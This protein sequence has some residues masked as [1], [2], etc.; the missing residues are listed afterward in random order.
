MAGTNLTFDPATGLVAPETTEIREAVAADW[1]GA[2]RENGC[3]DLEASPSTPA[4]QLI[5]AET[6]EIE[7]KNAQLLF[8]SSMFDP[9]TSVGR[10]QE[11]L[12][13][14][15][16]ISRKL[17]EPT[18][19]TCQLTGLNGTVIP[20]GSLVKNA[21]GYTFACNTP[22]TIG[23][24]GLAQTTFRLI[25]AGPI[26]VPAHSVNS[27]VTV[28]PGW[29]TVDNQA[30]GVVGRDIETRAEFEARRFA[31]VAA[32]AHGSVGAL[33]GTIANLPGVLDVQVLENIGPLPVEKFGVTVPGH[34]VTI[35]VYGGEDADIAEAI[36][37]K[38]DN[39]ADTGGNTEVTHV[40]TDYHGATYRYLIM[41][42][43][44]INFWVKVILGQ[45]NTITTAVLTALK[46]AIVDDFYGR[47]LNSRNSR[48]GLASTV[49][50]S[51]FYCP[52]L[53]VEGVMNIL[54]IEIALSEDRP[55][56][57][58]DLIVVNGDQEPTLALDNIDIEIG[59]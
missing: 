18:I 16:F 22:V 37:T 6:A 34:G 54:S 46:Q 44:P 50:A 14:I 48:V 57:Y 38:K 49:Y 25:E 23:A 40:A 58:S 7:A 32:N 55:D 43:T 27:I 56:S 59:G 1:I 31:S 47:N 42:P 26:E 41:R 51:R 36:Y 13:N 30:A 45:R 29:D 5:D 19:V 2:F 11:A 53:A 17:S 33:Y 12:G 35:C 9:F 24:D 52:A 3:P 15:Y 4:G 20:Y 21:A 39:G 28:I 8:L 10:W